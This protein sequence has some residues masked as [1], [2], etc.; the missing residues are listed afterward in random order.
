[1]LDFEVLDKKSLLGP[2]GNNFV[3]YLSTFADKSWKFADLRTG[4]SK[5][6]ADLR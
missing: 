2:F 5:K 4:T 6:F 1:M 3:Q